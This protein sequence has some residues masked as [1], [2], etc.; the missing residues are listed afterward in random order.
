VLIGTGRDLWGHWVK[1]FTLHMRKRGPE[2]NLTGF[3]PMTGQ[4]LSWSWCLPQNTPYC[5]RLLILKGRLF[6]YSVSI[7]FADVCEFS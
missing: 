2:K 7:V 4:C 6:R 5:I 3:T 1:T